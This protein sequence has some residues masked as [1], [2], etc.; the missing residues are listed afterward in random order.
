MRKIYLVM[1]QTGSILS[2]TI[3][4]VTGHSYNHI[5]ISLDN[6]LSRMYS[7]GRKNPNNPFIGVFV[8]EKINE[9]T[10]FKFKGTKCKVIEIEVTDRQYELISSNISSMVSNKGDFKYNLLGLF[11]AAF[12]I[13]F[14]PKNKY[15]C[16][17]FVR[18]ILSSSSVNV[19]MIPDIAHPNDFLKLDHIDLYEG[20]LSE[21]SFSN[22]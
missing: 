21:Y 18:Y 19:S 20:L 10:F 4:L 8:I 3:K 14:H 2:R 9:G 11:L 16:S 12:H 7:F 15:Y 1:T 17:E 6:N 13:S 5:S 22:V